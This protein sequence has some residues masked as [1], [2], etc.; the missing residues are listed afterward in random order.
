MHRR[1]PAPEPEIPT[2]LSIPHVP[3]LEVTDFRALQQGQLVELK[4]GQ[5]G[6]LLSVDPK[7][8]SETCALR[9]VRVV[10]PRDGAL[11]L[12]QVCELSAT[13]ASFNGTYLVHGVWFSNRGTLA[14]E[15]VVLEAIHR[16]FITARNCGV[17]W[18]LPAT[19]Q[20]SAQAAEQIESYLYEVAR[21]T[22]CAFPFHDITKALCH[23]HLRLST[24]NPAQLDIVSGDAISRTPKNDDEMLGVWA[25]T[26]QQKVML[27]DFS[28]PGTNPTR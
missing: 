12:G 10:W 8:E 5:H 18:P 27:S 24:A 3:P 28:L 16:G 19:W 23:M 7:A 2:E 11:P 1:P 21:S 4:D 6:V 17:T 20:L 13:A 15:R 14:P 22:G 9:Y 26:L 25:R